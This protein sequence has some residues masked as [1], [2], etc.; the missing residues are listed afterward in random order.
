MKP[1]TFRRLI[2]IEEVFNSDKEEFGGSGLFMN[3]EVK[4][5]D[6]GLQFKLPPLATVIFREHYPH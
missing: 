3:R 5:I 2:G 6:G 4:I 1:N